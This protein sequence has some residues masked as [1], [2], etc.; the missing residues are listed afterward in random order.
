MKSVEANVADKTVVVDADSSVTPQM[1]LE[2][3][4]KVR[5]NHACDIVKQCEL[6]FL[7]FAFPFL[8]GWF[9]FF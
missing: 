5:N 7:A 6:F 2:K 1:M 9:L 4:K 8:N 3:L